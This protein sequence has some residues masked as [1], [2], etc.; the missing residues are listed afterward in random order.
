[1]HKGEMVGVTTACVL[2]FVLVLGLAGVWF[3]Q[4]RKHIALVQRCSAANAA[5]YW[6]TLVVQE[7]CPRA[8]RAIPP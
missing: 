3:R 8:A 1:M 7:D 4:V 2:L 6:C 5:Q